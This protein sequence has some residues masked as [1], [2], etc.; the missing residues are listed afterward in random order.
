MQP[1]LRLLVGPTRDREVR[2]GR[3]PLAGGDEDMLVRVFWMMR[4]GGVGGSAESNQQAQGSEKTHCCSRYCSSMG[5]RGVLR[6][7]PIHH[8]VR[9]AMGPKP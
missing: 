6:G 2:W 4:R 8:L 9:V 5:D 1:I 3:H 7:C